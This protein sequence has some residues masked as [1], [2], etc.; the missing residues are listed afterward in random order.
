MDD[1]RVWAFEESL[2]TADAEH[3]QNAT[4]DAILMVLPHPPHVFDGQAAKD[5]VKATPRWQRVEFSDQRVSRPQEG[6]IVIAYRVHAG[7]DGEQDYVA[8][9]TSVYRRIAHEDWKVIQHQQTP[10]LAAS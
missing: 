4:D 8:H 3:Y 6:I 1:A 9:C 2:W 10:P 5:A 7:M